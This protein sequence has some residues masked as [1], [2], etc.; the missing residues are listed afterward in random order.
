V[1]GGNGRRA[2]GRNLL[3]LDDAGRRLPRPGGLHHRHR[4]RELHRAA[5][6]WLVP[7]SG[8]CLEGG[9]DGPTTGTCTN[10][11]Y[12]ASE[13]G[14]L[15]DCSTSA[16]C[17]ACT[18]RSAC[19]WCQSTT[20]CLNGSWDGPTTGTCASDWRYGDCEPPARLHHRHR[21]CHVLG[22]V[23]LRL[24]SGLHH[25]PERQ[26]RRPDRRGV[27]RLALLQLR[28]AARLHHRH[29]LRHVHGHV[30]CGWCVESAN[31]LNGSWDGPTTG[32]C[33]TWDWT[34]SDCG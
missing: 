29:R 8:G 13:C 2:D 18:D 25:L 26:L 33:T 14:A 12:V 24:V 19:G 4:L 5:E 28:P 21:L 17:A 1:P 15:I 32:T 3:R 23:G 31:C 34:T 11:M 7:D 20:S 22:H 6:L 30:G 27:H 10:W 9:S 16:D